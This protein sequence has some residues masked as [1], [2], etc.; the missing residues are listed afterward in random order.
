MKTRIV[1]M[2]WLAVAICIVFPSFQSSDN[3]VDLKPVANEAFKR[4]EKLTYR[5]HYGVMDA[6]HAVLEIK[7]EV[8]EIA[9]RKTFHAVGIGYSKGTFD[10]FFKVRD[11]YETY[12]DE[13][14]IIPWVFVRR[15]N[16]GGFKIEQDY[17]FNQYRKKVDANGTSYDVPENTQDM[18]SA[19]YSARCIDFSKAKTGEIF[20]I[21]SFVDKELFPLKIKYIGKETISTSL[22]KFNCIKFRPVIQ[23]GR[24][25]KHEE[26]L[27][28]WITD[29]KNHIPLRAEAKILV[30]SIKMDLE[31]YEGLANPIAKV[32]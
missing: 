12:I 23:K 8:K 14:A 5:I 17:I 6:G 24:V 25:F 13:D 2:L 22:G 3:R 11:K 10:W 19:F 28:V 26:D 9:G 18:L 15:V 1:C 31:K 32:Q 4:G 20:T 29:D 27:N 21:N 16:E 30:G 7:D